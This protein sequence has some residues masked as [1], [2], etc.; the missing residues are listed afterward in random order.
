MIGMHVAAI[1]II[2]GTVASLCYLSKE[3]LSKMFSRINLCFCDC[4]DDCISACE[5]V[6]EDCIS[7]YDDLKDDFITE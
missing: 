4:K 5:D 7:A 6:K 1:L 2:G 3:K